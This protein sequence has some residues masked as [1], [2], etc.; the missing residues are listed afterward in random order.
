MLVL[1]S[2]RDAADAVFAGVLAYLALGDGVDVDG[3]TFALGE[4]VAVHLF[5]YGY[6]KQIF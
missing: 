4:V 1:Y 3:T 6:K 2:P 5:F